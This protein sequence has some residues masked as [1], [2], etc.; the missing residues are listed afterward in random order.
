MPLHDGSAGKH[1]VISS[2]DSPGNP[3]YHGGGAAVV[4][5]IARLLGGA[6]RGHGGHC[7]T[8]RRDGSA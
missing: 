1:I 4:D 7:G 8:P 6:L 3:H 5:T 2:F